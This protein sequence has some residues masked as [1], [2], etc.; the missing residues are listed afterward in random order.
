[1]KLNWITAKLICRACRGE[2]I[3]ELL[4]A[5]PCHQYLSLD[6]FS[7]NQRKKGSDA[8]VSL[9][10]IPCPEQDADTVQ[11]CIQCVSWYET[12]EDAVG[13]TAVPNGDMAPDEL[14]ALTID[15][16]GYG[17]W[18]GPEGEADSDDDV[19]THTTSLIAVILTPLS[20][21]LSTTLAPQLQLHPY[22]PV[23]HSTPRQSKRLQLRAVRPRRLASFHINAECHPLQ[24]QATLPIQLPLRPRALASASTQTSI[25]VLLPTAS[26][27]DHLLGLN[28]YVARGMLLLLPQLSKV[29]QV[30]TQT[31]TNRTPHDFSRL[32]L[33]CDEG[34]Y[35]FA[36]DLEEFLCKLI[37]TLIRKFGMRI[38]T[39]TTE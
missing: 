22:Q 10:V 23:I 37:T 28:Q 8:S 7:K 20:W 9:L 18:D 5:G 32:E 15:E 19:V 27:T 2:S 29:Y 4:C 33:L 16:S 25:V 26:R 14:E 6:A 17:G 13:T 31:L 30:S 1:M 39:D 35:G 38:A 11:T 34:G 24:V 36:L 3:N 21:L 12:Q